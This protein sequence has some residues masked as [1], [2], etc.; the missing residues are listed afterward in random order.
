MERLDRTAW[1]QA[2]LSAFSEGGLPA[3]RVELLP[4]CLK[5]T[6]GSFYWHFSGREDLLG[7]M[8]DEWERSQVA[9]VIATVEAR[10]CGPQERFQHLSDALRG[11]DLWLEAAVRSWAAADPDVV[12]A[13]EGIYA[14]R[15]VYLQ[16]IIERAG[17]PAD[18][19]Q[20]RASR[21]FCPDRRIDQRRAKL[22][23]DSPRSHGLESH[24]VSCL[25]VATD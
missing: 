5:I 25:A 11:L 17:V 23:P 9:G 20:A 19:A 18:P 24:H 4:K 10:G 13:V 2:G 22:V 6:K 8:L 3:V 15:L 12:C 16:S 1:V 7:A 21:L 14:A